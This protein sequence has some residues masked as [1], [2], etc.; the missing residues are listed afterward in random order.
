M[1]LALGIIM[2]ALCIVVSIKIC[3]TAISGKPP[4]FFRGEDEESDS[5]QE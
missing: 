1:A 3:A 4:P 2:L 5:L